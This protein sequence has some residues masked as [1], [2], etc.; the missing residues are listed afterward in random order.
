MDVSN[1]V[2]RQL[3]FFLCL[4]SFLSCKR[5]ALQNS[6]CDDLKQVDTILV[7]IEF[8]SDLN[9]YKQDEDQVVKIGY[10]AGFGDSL[11]W[12]GGIQG[13]QFVS[14]DM[15]NVRLTQYWSNKVDQ[16][17]STIK[18]SVLGIEICDECLNVPSVVTANRD[19]IND[20]FELAGSYCNLLLEVE[21]EYGQQIS[22]DYPSWEYD[23]PE[24]KYFYLCE[25]ELAD[26]RIVSKTGSFILTHASFNTKVHNHS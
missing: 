22:C 8:P 13:S 25:V 9:I 2:N 7:N 5:E 6:S 14:D 4:L 21:N 15:G 23:Q 26:G 19:G 18:T 10:H 1:K 20:R 16:D 17:L 12:T 11:S 3:L 24:G